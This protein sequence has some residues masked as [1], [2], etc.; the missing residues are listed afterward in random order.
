MAEVK[1]VN[2][3]V[4]FATNLNLVKGEVVN[5][6]DSAASQLDVYSETGNQE[7]LRMFLAEVQQIRGT[8][9]LLDFRAGE[10]LCE[11]FAESGRMARGER[12]ADNTLS[13]FTQA[14]VYLKRFVELIGEGSP[15]SP[16]LLVPTINLIR[17]D[18]ND[19]PLP[20]SYFFLVNLRPQVSIPKH[21]PNL[22]K[23]PFRRARQ[24]YQLGLLAL[25][26]KQ[27]RVGPVQVMNRAVQRFES[28]SRGG[29]SWLFWHV[30]N[31]AMDALAQD[32][33]EITPSRMALLAQLDKQVRRI[34]ETE[35]RHFS[36]K[37]PDWL[38][39]EFVHI[40]SL[41]EPVT[42]LIQQ[43]QQEFHI[44]NCIRESQVAD[45]RQ[46]LS[47]PDGSA[48]ESLA[49]ALL[50]ELQKI[51]DQ[52]DLIE[53]ID[54]SDSDFQQLLDGLRR[55]G[56]TLG[57]ANSP[58]AAERAIE[59]ALQLEAAGPAGLQQRADTIADEVIKLEQTLRSLSSHGGATESEIDPVS[60]NEARIAILSES[61]TALAMIKRAIGS[62][63]ESDGDVLHV[64]NVSKCLTDVAGALL[65][66]GNQQMHDIIESLR[67]F[68]DHDVLDPNKQIPDDKMEAFADAI[69][70]IEYFMD[71][72][73]GQGSGA[74]EAV[75]LAQDSLEHL[76]G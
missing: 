10:R 75:R 45:V 30:A 7:S 66:L 65:F 16:S 11:E 41:A 46:Q 8:F 76:K 52:I 74:D 72:M 5:S 54:L 23:F 60:L 53:R 36:E 38:L 25:I 58:A 57:I 59:L 13:V 39:K 62:Y 28:A 71:S 34:Q 49:Q 26:R 22:S 20:D 24:M 47:G 73:A 50:E 61:M 21:D 51:K 9:K 2:D 6:L 43:V 48:L 12:L 68:V 37:L 33:F 17:R 35:G 63:L 29:A 4:Q 64:A 14:I 27:G 40:V 70:A 32:N 69:T 1:T 42:P 56:D 18:R 3:E 15:V 19:A 55:I 31:A 67:E 44:E